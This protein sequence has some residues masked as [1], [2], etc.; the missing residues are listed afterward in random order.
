MSHFY[1]QMQGA[2]GMASRCGSKGSGH[3]C[4]I[5]GWNG[6]VEVKAHYR[7]M[8]GSDLFTVWLTSGSNGGASDQYLGVLIVDPDGVRTWEPAPRVHI[9]T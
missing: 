9:T 8:D 2:R 7:E 5:R 1:A 4:H 6:G 3:W